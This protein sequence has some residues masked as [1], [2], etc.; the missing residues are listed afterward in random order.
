MR[1]TKQLIVLVGDHTKNMHKFVRWEI[2]IA[3]DMDI[4]VIAVN[5][6]GSNGSTAKT[7]PI[8]KNNAYF[9]SVPFEM[10]KIKHALDN[11]PNEYHKNKD[12]DPSDRYYDWSRI[13]I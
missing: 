2:D 12:E 9:V 7:P 5:L 10:K 1:N 6:D 4:P 8:L 11:F 3:M 13:T